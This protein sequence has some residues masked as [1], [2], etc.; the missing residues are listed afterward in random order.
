MYSNVEHLKK[1]PN[2][3]LVKVNSNHSSYKTSMYVWLHMKLVY[4]SKQSDINVFNF[5]SLSLLF[6][7]A[8][9]VVPDGYNSTFSLN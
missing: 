1:R 9:Q 8:M 5:L 2:S 7:F 4:P 3:V 6:H